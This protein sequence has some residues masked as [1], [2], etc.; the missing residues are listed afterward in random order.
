MQIIPLTNI[1]RQKMITILGEQQ[2]SLQIWWQ[3][4]SEAW[5]LSLEAQTQLPIALGRQVSTHRRLLGERRGGGFK[6]EIAVVPR[7][8]ENTEAL[9]REPWGATH[10]MVYLT[11]ADTREVDWQP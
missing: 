8:G 10:D 9:G 7:G 6:G 5:Y 3:P 1:A 11:E 4:L 2:V